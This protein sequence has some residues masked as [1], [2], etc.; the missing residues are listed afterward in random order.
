MTGSP[1][2]PL[3][4]GCLC[5]AVRY[6]LTLQPR[7][8]YHCHCSICRKCQGALFPTYA[9]VAREG[10]RIVRGADA[11]SSYNSS[12]ELRRDFCSRCG[13]HVY[14]EVE[15]DPDTVTFSVGTLDGGADPGGRAGTER[16][17]F[18]ESRCGWYE[19]DDGLPRVV[20]FG[21]DA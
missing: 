2:Y 15:G 4:G 6:E 11:L 12:P 8:V 9:T 14:G 16:H 13:A 1:Q 3:P 5:G 20:E 18:W 17:I 7:H 10:F 21:D 19:P